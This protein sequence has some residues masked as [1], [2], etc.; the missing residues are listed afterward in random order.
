MRT[1]KILALLSFFLGSISFTYAQDST[2]YK[3]KREKW[4]T[5]PN[6]LA[7]LFYG[8]VLILQ[9]SQK[10]LKLIKKPEIEEKVIGS[11]VEW[12]VHY[13]INPAW[14]TTNDEGK[15]ALSDNANMYSLLGADKNEYV[16]W[17]VIYSV[18][19]E[20]G[21][22]I[23]SDKITWG[24]PP[25]TDLTVRMK[26]NHIAALILN[27]GILWMGITGSELAVN[28]SLVT[29]D[30]PSYDEKLRPFGISN[31]EVRI[32][33][34]LGFQVKVGLRSEEKGIDFIVPETGSASVFIPKGS[35]EIYF[36]FS[37]DPSNL[38]KGDN[39]EL[40]SDGIEIKLG[41]DTEGNYNV[42]KV[43]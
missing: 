31:A 24:I 26:I 30:W 38:Y 9:P 25:N 17:V 35:Y 5:D 19:V 2:L 29:C 28:T 3:V 13:G 7:K 11:Y 37:I 41:I 33:N 43:K 14:L 23:T 1:I 36:Q 16:G 21:T 6:E 18:L 15:K 4:Q 8:D 42:K 32:S 20:E 40:V 27:N 22:E 34:T 12:Q 39:F 10:T